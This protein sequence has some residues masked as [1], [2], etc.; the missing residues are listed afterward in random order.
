MNITLDFRSDTPLYEQLLAQI[1]HL[2]VS[3]TLRPGDQLPPVRALADEIKINFNTV[4]RVYRLLD[5]EGLISTQHGRGTFILGSSNE[6]RAAK[7]REEDFERLTQ[8]YL[9]ESMNL[10]YTVAE[11]E[12]MLCTHLAA[13]EDE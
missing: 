3:G 4:A 5:A 9:S 1:K 8:T 6:E 10:G 13:L 12:T 2:I 11:I 7:L